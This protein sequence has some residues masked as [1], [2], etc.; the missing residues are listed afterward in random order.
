[1][2]T[3]TP[4]A[5]HVD[6]D[7]S[8][9]PPGHGELSHPEL[10]PCQPMLAPLHAAV[11]NQDREWRRQKGAQIVYPTVGTRRERFEE[12]PV[13]KLPSGYSKV[14]TEFVPPGQSRIHT[15]NSQKD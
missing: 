1:M 12:S 10:R 7:A 4:P 8:D 6:V 5:P 3:L 15:G 14:S 13:S 2:P 11:L 9:L